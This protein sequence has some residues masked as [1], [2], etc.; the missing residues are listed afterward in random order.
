MAFIDLR[1]CTNLQPLPL[2]FLTGRMRM[3]Q[4][5]VHGMIS[6]LL[7]CTDIKGFMPSITF[8]PNGNW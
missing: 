4:G 5:L 7:M 8:C 3:L 1:S 6:P 2:G